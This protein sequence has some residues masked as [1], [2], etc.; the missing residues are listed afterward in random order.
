[1]GFKKDSVKLAQGVIDKH[2]V[3]EDGG[4]HPSGFECVFCQSGKYK[5]PEDIKHDLDCEVLIAIDLVTN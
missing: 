5:E 4:D 3:Y 2:A 1:M